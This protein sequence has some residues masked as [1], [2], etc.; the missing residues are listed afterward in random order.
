MKNEAEQLEMF[1]DT[2]DVYYNG[3]G[4]PLP[5]EEVKENENI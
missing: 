5:W 2:G 4:E 3:M 1:K